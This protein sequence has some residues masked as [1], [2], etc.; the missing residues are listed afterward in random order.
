M[1]AAVWA[2][3]FTLL[4][5]PERRKAEAWARAQAEEVLPQDRGEAEALAE[6][7]PTLRAEAA[8]RGA[9]L[10]LPGD[11]EADRFQ[12]PLPYPLALWVRGTLPPPRPALAM[13]GSRHGSFAGRERTR[14]WAREL[15]ER[16]VA[17]ISGL[18]RGIDGAAH[19]GAL[20][21]GATWGIMGSGLDH[22]YPLEHQKL[23]DRMAA[24]G[25]GVITPFPPQARPLKWHFP[26]RNVLLAVWTLGVIV[27]EARYA[28][29]SLVTA[30]LALDH[31]KELWACPGAPED[32]L[33]EGPNRLIRE[34][35]ARAC[36]GPQ[37]LIDDLS[38]WG[39]GLT[40][41]P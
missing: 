20:E 36:L 32:P 27:M 19:L 17:V 14:R 2:L 18:A 38:F 1:D 25:G 11:P 31:G 29:G 10:V 40:N 22:P 26:R 21:A 4:P 7:L 41:H 39:Q 6:S 8:A 13:V 37:D 24:T 28:S 34:G 16:G 3:A 30:K 15:T 9:R 35:A 5:W 23:M 12:A 33:H